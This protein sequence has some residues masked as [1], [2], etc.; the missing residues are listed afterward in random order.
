[1]FECICQVNKCVIIYYNCVYS[2]AEKDLAAGIRHHSS[3][4]LSNSRDMVDRICYP[5]I[6]LKQTGKLLYSLK[7]LN[8][9]QHPS[10]SCLHTDS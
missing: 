10:V 4:W 2:I 9:T 5:F 1:M 8:K 6:K 3:L 7:R